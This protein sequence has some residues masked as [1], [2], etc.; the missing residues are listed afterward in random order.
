MSY[1]SDF[2]KV[3][4]HLKTELGSVRT[5][6]ASPA[7]V[8]DIRVECYGDALPIKQLANIS[9]PEANM[10]II[11]PWD[12]SLTKNIEKAIQFSDLG[13]NPT[14]EGTLLRLFLPPLTEERRL[15]LI[16]VV[17]KKMEES[18]IMLRTVREKYLKTI[19]EQEASGE[20]SEDDLHKQQ[21]ELQAAVDDANEAIREMGAKKEQEISTL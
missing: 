8:E 18:R 13:M 20:I 19:R 21:K 11:E 12:K 4:D 2:Q 10:I 9:V 1:Q 17:H 6:R 15:E 16:K 5:G 3:I 14:N 7:L